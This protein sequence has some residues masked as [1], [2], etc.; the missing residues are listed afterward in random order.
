MAIRKREYLDLRARIS[1][2]RPADLKVESC[3]R[4]CHR[5]AAIVQLLMMDRADRHNIGGV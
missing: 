4:N 1:E 3:L 5:D 2:V